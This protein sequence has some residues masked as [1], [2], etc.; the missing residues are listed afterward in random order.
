MLLNEVK[1]DTTKYKETITELKRKY[2]IRKASRFLIGA[3][4]SKIHWIKQEVSQVQK[5]KKTFIRHLSINTQTE[6]SCVVEVDKT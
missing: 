3:L 5:I 4:S 6:T 2:Q 1:D